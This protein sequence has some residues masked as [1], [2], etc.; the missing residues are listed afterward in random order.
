V[1]PK[2]ND[3]MEKLG[4]DALEFIAKENKDKNVLITF[5]SMG[6]TDAVSSAVSLLDYFTNAR[7]ATPDFVTPN[8]ARILKKLGFEP[9]MI[10]NRFDEN[11]DLVIMTDV[12]NFEDCGPFRYKLENFK[13]NILIIDHHMPKEIA[14]EH[15]SV[16]NNESYNSACSIVYELLKSLGV[17]MSETTSKI[18]LSGILSDSA[19]LKNAGSRTF[20]QIGEL[21]GVIGMDYPTFLDQMV[22][23]ADVQGRAKTLNDIVKANVELYGDVLI[24]HGRAHSHAN[25]AA[26]YAIKIGADVGFFYAE[27]EKEISFSARMRPP[28]D[29][30]F[31]IHLGVLTKSIA[32]KL[33]GNGGGHPCAAGAYGPLGSAKPEEIESLFISEVLKRAK[34]ANATI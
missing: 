19:D 11:V 5:H 24:M 16:F 6:D 25:I 7:L 32:T 30:K 34:V 13:G 12:N 3:V 29:K 21:L 4:F 33:N 18:I 20:M 14:K 22:H 26:D 15:V 2:N 28:L 1:K 17:G 8:A 27:N 23:V 9:E 31:G 10:T